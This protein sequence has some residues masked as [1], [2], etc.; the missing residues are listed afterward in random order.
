[1]RLFISLGQSSVNELKFDQG[2]VYVGRQMG[3][4]VFLPD[5]AVSR[6]HA[7]FYTTK[8]GNWVIEDLGSSNK[9]YLNSHPIHK[10]ELKHNDVV[11]IADFLIRVSLEPD[12]DQNRRNELE[13]TL[14]VEHTAVARDLHTVE[15]NFDALD[16]PPV[17][18]AVKRIKQYHE[19]IEL[20]SKATKLDMLYKNLM[21][22][23]F[24]QF[25]AK[26]V[27]MAFRK[28]PAG[29]M[30]IEGGR[31]ITTEHIDRTD[32]AVPASLAEALAG[33]KYL[34]I[35]QLPRQ[36]IARGI[37]SVMITPILTAH[38]C[39]GVIYVAN[40]TDHPHYS[41]AEMDYLI[42]LSIHVAYCIEKL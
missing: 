35:H 18:F 39:H 6:Q 8:D 34:L 42:L 38:T 23:L 14:T 27:W 30:D 10:S 28:A 22:L 21:D 16:A 31:Q 32:L 13:D 11:R 9:T 1:M 26:H 41:L 12:E 5:K 37:R 19:A 36:I 3:S 17:K 20:I 4:Q 2:P 15:R 40:S 33:N 24:R 29:P 25:I 7:V